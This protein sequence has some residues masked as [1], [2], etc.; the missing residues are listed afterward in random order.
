VLATGGG[1]V[2]IGARDRTFRAVDARAGQELWRTVLPAVP[3]GFPLTYGVGGVQYVAIVAGGRGQPIEA[4]LTPMTPENLP[5]DSA[6]TLMV[7]AL[8]WPG[9]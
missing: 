5:S 8:P 4:F 7:F 1:L 6:K 3:V 9:R 2:F